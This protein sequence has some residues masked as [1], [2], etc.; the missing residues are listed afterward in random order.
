MAC[1]NAVSEDRSAQSSGDR[2]AK[3][4]AAGMGGLIGHT[5][6]YTVLQNLTTQ[7]Q[8]LAKLSVPDGFGLTLAAPPAGP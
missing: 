1:G 4:Y 8:D 7:H 2:R 3:R 5:R 6:Y